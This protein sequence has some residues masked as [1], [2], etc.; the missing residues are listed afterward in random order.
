[1]DGGGTGCPTASP[2]EFSF[3]AIVNGNERS[4]SGAVVRM[5]ERERGVRLRWE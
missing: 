5:Q 4:R 3:V 2:L 1:M